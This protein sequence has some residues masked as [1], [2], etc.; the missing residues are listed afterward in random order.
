MPETSP[1]APPHGMTGGRRASLGAP[2]HRRGEM[3]Q[4]RASPLSQIRPHNCRH[5]FG[6]DSARRLEQWGHEEFMAATRYDLL[7]IGNAIVDVIARTDDDFLAAHRMRK[8]TMQLIDEARATGLYD[9]MGP[10]VE[11]SGGSA[12]NTIVGAASLGARTAFIG[13]VKDDE[14]G[15]VFAHDI[16]AAGVAFA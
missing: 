10:A 9:A 14:L 8:G 15:R 6:R 4:A 5:H 7:G 13:K 11:I 1:L 3:A 12:A 16:R 2:P